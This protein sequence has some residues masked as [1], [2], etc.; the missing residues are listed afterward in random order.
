MTSKSG[1]TGSESNGTGGVCRFRSPRRP[2]A[3]GITDFRICDLQKTYGWWTVSETRSTRERQDTRSIEPA[4]S[5]RLLVNVTSF[6]LPAPS[7]KSTT[8]TVHSATS[9]RKYPTTD[10]GN[11]FQQV[12][13]RSVLPVGVVES[14]SVLL[15]RTLF[16]CDDSMLFCPLV[17][18]CHLNVFIR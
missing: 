11:P 17:R 15:S 9:T 12:V 3:C 13:A 10:R 18:S 8:R 16:G 1:R 7:Q 2:H 6:S 5:R 14:R 4:P